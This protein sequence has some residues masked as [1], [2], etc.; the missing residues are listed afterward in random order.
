MRGEIDSLPPRKAT[1]D[2]WTIT[3]CDMPTRSGGGRGLLQT[4]RRVIDKFLQLGDDAALIE[5]NGRSGKSIYASL[6]AE[7]KRTKENRCYPTVRAGKCYLV[8]VPT[9][10]ERR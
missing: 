5:M 8:R 4:Y 1:V 10:S 6:N 7:C 2:G 3:A 9:N